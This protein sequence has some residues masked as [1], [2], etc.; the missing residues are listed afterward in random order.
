[1]VVDSDQSI[2]LSY[3]IFCQQHSMQVPSGEKNQLDMNNHTARSFF[4]DLEIPRPSLDD[5]FPEL[6]S[7]RN[8]RFFEVVPKE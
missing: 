1:M 5:E 8:H 4:E 7:M 3:R 6:C 2:H